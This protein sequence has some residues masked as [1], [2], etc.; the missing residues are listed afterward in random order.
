MKNI[1]APCYKTGF[2]P[3]VLL[4]WG[5]LQRGEQGAEG[6][7]PQ[8]ARRASSFSPTRDVSALEMRALY[9]AAGLIARLQEIFWR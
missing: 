2:L 7:F 6:L 5:R 9:K 3:L 4:L 1:S 8:P